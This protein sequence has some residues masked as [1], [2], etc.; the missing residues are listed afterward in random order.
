MAAHIALIGDS[1]FDNGAYTGGGISTTP[2]IAQAFVQF[3]GL[4][5][6]RAVSF[7]TDPNLPAPNFGDLRFDDPANAEVNLLAYTFSFGNGF[8]ATGTVVGTDADDNVY[9]T[10]AGKFTGKTALVLGVKYSF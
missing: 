1:V 10:P 9:V 2:N 4:T 3:G 6:G 7:F 8:S 5:A